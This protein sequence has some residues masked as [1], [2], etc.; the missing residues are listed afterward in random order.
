[1][2]VSMHGRTLVEMAVVRI[3]SLEDLDELAALVAEIRGGV[4]VSGDA[5]PQVEERPARAA[6]PA[7]ATLV[8]QPAAKK[9]VESVS[10]GA[11][12]R[13]PA[14]PEMLS[15]TAP[16]RRAENAIENVADAGVCAAVSDNGAPTGSQESVPSK[17]QQAI[18]SAAQSSSEAAPRSSR[19]SRREQLAEVAERPL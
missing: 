11:L 4:K 17:F 18:T 15:A 10:N 3:C 8:E 5:R 9:N 13:I 6:S 2:R 1:M 19:P 7:A 12:G 14:P 16:E